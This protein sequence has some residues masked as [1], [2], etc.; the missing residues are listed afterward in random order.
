MTHW[1]TWGRG[2]RRSSPRGGGT[3]RERLRLRRGA[4]LLVQSRRHVGV[5][6]L[7]GGWLLLLS[8]R[9]FHAMRTGRRRWW[10]GAGQDVLIANK[11]CLHTKQRTWH[12]NPTL[13]KQTP[14]CAH[15]LG[16]VPS[17]GK[18][19]T[20]RR[21]K[22]SSK[23]KAQPSEGYKNLYDLLYCCLQFWIRKKQASSLLLHYVSLHKK[24]KSKSVLSNTTLRHYSQH[25]CA[26]A[27]R[28]SKTRHMQTM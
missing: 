11:G 10:M 17:L 24:Q 25:S 8:D 15:P 9:V 3:F 21:H 18:A 20:A 6:D 5:K 13:G 23:C 22:P 12:A 7:I 2:R 1:R 27:C 28:T 16:H 26:R 14:P 19:Q 4:E